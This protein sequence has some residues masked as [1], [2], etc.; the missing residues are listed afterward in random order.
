MEALSAGAD[1]TDTYR[2]AER[3]LKDAWAQFN[4]AAGTDIRAY[5]RAETGAG[6]AA[7]LFVK[8]A[9]DAK[10]QKA[11]R[12]AMPVT[13]PAAPV[14][15]QK[16]PEPQPPPPEP[17]PVVVTTTTAE[18]VVQPVVEPEVVAPAPILGTDSGERK[19][20]LVIEVVP[21][22]PTVAPQT[23]SARTTNRD[24]LQ[25]A[26]RAYATGDLDLS[27]R[28]LS[29][30]LLTS[31][32][33]EVYLLRGCARYARAILSRNEALLADATSDFKAALKLNRSLRLDRS[34]F[35]PKLVAFFETVRKAS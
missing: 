26:Y 3:K 14:V 6:Q 20:P 10:R 15:V 11:S 9:D 12:P 31:P 18:P 22:R 28:T 8:A 16:A 19:P 34:V 1:R 33:G 29:S 4:T 25:F 2:A 32:S 17:Q 27:E 35:S 7:E 24:L 21:S 30:M 5:E 13:K 23:L